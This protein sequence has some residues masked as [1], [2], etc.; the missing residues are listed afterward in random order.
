MD[1]CLDCGGGGVGAAEKKLIQLDRNPRAVRVAL[2]FKAEED[3]AN[4]ST[5]A[6]GRRHAQ[7]AAEQLFWVSQWYHSRIEILTLVFRALPPRYSGK[8]GRNQF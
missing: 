2:K 5:V 1:L 3:D 7:T 8:R 6:K 4:V